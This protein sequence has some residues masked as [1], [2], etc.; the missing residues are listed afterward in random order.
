MGSGRATRRTRAQLVPALERVAE[1]TGRVAAT[2]V[3]GR[4]FGTTANDQAMAELG[5][6]RKPVQG[7]S[8]LSTARPNCRSVPGPNRANVSLARH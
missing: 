4:G 3:G 7:P 6:K 2:V 5:V 1:V 8:T